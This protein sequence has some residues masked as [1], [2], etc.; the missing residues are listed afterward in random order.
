MF[1]NKKEGK[2]ASGTEADAGAN[3]QL[4]GI[5]ERIIAEY[6]RRGMI[7][8]AIAFAESKVGVERAIQVCVEKEWFGYAA[9]LAENN[10]DAE[11]ATQLRA[12]GIEVYMKKGMRV[13]A[14][15]LAAKN[16]DI[17]GAIQTYVDAGDPEY[18]AD[19]AEKNGYT[20]RAIQLRAKEIEACEKR[21]D[22][23]H[24]ADLA[25]KN[26]DAERA[27]AYRTLASILRS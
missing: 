25:E 7:I 2:A 18:A 21:G 16:G 6:L 24:A 12:E 17:E 23:D 5:N 11:R 22:Y 26:G 13:D 1:G 8:K 14:A 4:E 10:G 15:G 9:N 19:L 20:E 3:S 27:E